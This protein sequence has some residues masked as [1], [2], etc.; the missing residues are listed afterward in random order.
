[1]TNPQPQGPSEADAGVVSA[2]RRKALIDVFGEE[3][4]NTYQGPVMYMDREALSSPASINLYNR[5]FK[6]ISKSLQHE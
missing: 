1:M 3:F 2:T 6:F 4:A 5:D